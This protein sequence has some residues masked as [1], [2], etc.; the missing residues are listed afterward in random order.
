MYTQLHTFEPIRQLTSLGGISGPA[1]ADNLPGSAQ[2]GAVVANIG[3]AF[4]V[5]ATFV[6]TTWC[7]NPADAANLV[8]PCAPR[9]STTLWIIDVVLVTLV[10]QV[11]VIVYAVAKWFKRPSG[12]S[13]DPTTIAGVTAVMGHPE[14][15][16]LFAGMPGDI[17]KKELKERLRGRRFRLGTYNMADGVTKYGLMP[18]DGELEGKKESFMERFKGGLG[19]IGDRL[20]LSSSWQNNRAYID[21]V[22]ALIVLALLGLTVAAVANVDKPQK[23]FLASAASS[24][25]GMRIFFAILGII[26]SS[27]WG[28]L[29]QGKANPLLELMSLSLTLANPGPVL[30]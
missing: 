28:R 11:I 22:F 27:Y 3:S 23:V 4:A 7:V 17:S 2:L 1:L 9:V 8:N 30:R 14:I 19:N 13:G 24:G 26:M 15:E 25:L 21:L 20:S 6:D 10:I 16:A 5:G 29:F 18:A 12:V